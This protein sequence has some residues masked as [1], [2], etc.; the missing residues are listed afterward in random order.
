MGYETD[1]GHKP[2]SR[3][4]WYLLPRELSKMWVSSDSSCGQAGFPEWK[5]VLRWSGSWCIR[6]ACC[7]VCEKRCSNGV[8][9]DQVIEAKRMERE[10]WQC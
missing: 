10:G 3:E 1:N 6:K 5:R 2:D 4:S 9:G 7:V 8:E